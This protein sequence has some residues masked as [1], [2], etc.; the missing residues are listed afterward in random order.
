LNGLT[1]PYDS[2][3]FKVEAVRDVG[4]AHRST[5]VTPSVAFATPLSRSMYAGLSLS[6]DFV[7]NRF[8]DY[9]FGVSPTDALASGVRTYNPRGGFK[10]WQAG[11]L[12]NK[13][14]TGDLTHGLSLF[15][16]VS[17]KRMVRDFKRSP[18][19]A[20]R[21]SAQQWFVGTGL[22]YTW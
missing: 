19:V 12:V 15:G 17:S 22:G 14:L 3:S 18:L 21:G 11:L 16:L 1:N 6:A 10:S 4:N 9:Y 20:D 13:S 8:A 5:V 2:L 7:Q